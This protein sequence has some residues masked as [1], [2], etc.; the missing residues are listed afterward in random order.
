MWGYSCNQQCGN[1]V[2]NDAAADNGD[3][4]NLRPPPGMGGLAAP[5]HVASTTGSE[6]CDLGEYNVDL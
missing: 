1:G 4:D 3:G 2:V 6:E 5:P